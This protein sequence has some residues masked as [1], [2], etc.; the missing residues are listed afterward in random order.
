MYRQ[1]FCKRKLVLLF[2]DN[3]DL[4][5][6]V[7]VNLVYNGTEL[8]LH[9]APKIWELAPNDVKAFDPVS[10]EIMEA[11]KMFLNNLQNQNSA[12]WLCVVRA[13]SHFFVLNSF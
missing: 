11:S 6:S 8:L 1:K 7:P 2:L 9:L 10:D 4:F 5:Y 12:N 3:A 13:I